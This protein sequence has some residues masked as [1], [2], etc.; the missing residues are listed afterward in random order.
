MEYGNFV[1]HSSMAGPAVVRLGVDPRYDAVV[2]ADAICLDES[3]STAGNL[4][5]FPEDPRMEKEQIPGTLNPF[6]DKMVHQVVMGQVAIDASDGPVHPG[7]EPGLVRI[8][9][10]MAAIAESGC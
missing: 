5:R 9:H 10:Y 2:A 8:V 1:I 6:P 4:D 7:H 3:F